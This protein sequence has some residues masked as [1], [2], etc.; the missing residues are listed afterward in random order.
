MA[1]TLSSFYP[2]H[3]RLSLLFRPP[4]GPWPEAGSRRAPS[5]SGSASPSISVDSE[6]EKDEQRNDETKKEATASHLRGEILARVW[7]IL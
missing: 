4:L 5:S 3:P 6:D 1:N 2:H 7:G